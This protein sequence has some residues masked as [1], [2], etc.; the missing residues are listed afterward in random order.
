MLI[1]FCSIPIVE[2][3]IRWNPKFE[4]SDTAISLR[5]D[6]HATLYGRAGIGTDIDAE[7]CYGAVAGAELFAQIDAPL[8]ALRPAPIFIDFGLCLDC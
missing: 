1:V 7:V 6:T 8:V 3:G 2:F 4:V 5:C